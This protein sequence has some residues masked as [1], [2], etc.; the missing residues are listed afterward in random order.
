MVSL[1]KTILCLILIL[2]RKTRPKMST[3]GIYRNV[4]RRNLSLDIILHFGRMK[5]SFFLL[6]CSQ[7]TNVN[8]SRNMKKGDAQVHRTD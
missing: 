7:Q 4:L 6:N 1:S 3:Q 5:G 2:P 8:E